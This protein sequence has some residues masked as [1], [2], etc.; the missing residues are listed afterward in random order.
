MESATLNREIIKRVLRDPRGMKLSRRVRRERLTY[1]GADALLDL[2]DLVREADHQGRPGSIVEAGVALG[3]SAVMLAVSKSAD[4][5]LELYDVFG[6]IPPP[7]DEDGDDVLDRY[8]TIVSG[9]SD[10][11]DGDLYYG[12]HE[13]LLRHVERTLDRFGVSRNVELIKGFYSDTLH[14]GEVAVAHVDADWYES[15]HTC[16]QRIW[17]VLAPGGVIVLD[18]YDH[19]SGCRKAVDEWLDGRT[20]VKVERRSR[21]HLVRQGGPTR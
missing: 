10:G 7:S 12:Y 17:P 1:L 5:R 16:L 11:I 18:D 14:P 8:Q 3:G 6:R 13:D 20:D 19:W 4:R 9:R 21:L 2:R 15:V